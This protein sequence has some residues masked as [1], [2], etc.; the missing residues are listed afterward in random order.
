MTDCM[1]TDDG[2]SRRIAARLAARSEIQDVRLLRTRADVHDAPDPT[3]GLTY[4]I[5][6]TPSIDADPTITSTFVVRIGCQLRIA[7]KTPDSDAEESP[8]DGADDNDTTSSVLVASADFEYAAVF[9]YTLRDGDAAPSEE[10][11]SAFATSTGRFALYPYIREYIYDLTG[12]LALPPLTIEV[13]KL[14]LP[15]GKDIDH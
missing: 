8:Q 10:E 12:R 13:L 2:E 4:D 6:F 1:T 5:E 15:F 14:S 3:L 9:D 11:L 7:N